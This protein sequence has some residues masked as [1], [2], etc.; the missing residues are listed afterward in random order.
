MPVPTLLVFQSLKDP[1]NHVHR[2]PPPLLPP[3]T[4][5][6]RMRIPQCRPRASGN[7]ESFRIAGAVV[8]FGTEQDNRFFWVSGVN[9]DQ[10]PIPD[11][12]KTGVHIAFKAKGNFKLSSPLVRLPDVVRIS[13]FCWG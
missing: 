1:L 10:A 7:Q 12:Q 11:D 4:P 3:H 9:R 8:A 2:P 6:R 5:Q 13:S